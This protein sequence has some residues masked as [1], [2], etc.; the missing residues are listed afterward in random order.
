MYYTTDINSGEKLTRAEAFPG[1]AFPGGIPSEEQLADA[2]YIAVDNVATDV[3]IN[4]K[5]VE[6]SPYQDSEGSWKTYKELSTQVYP[7]I[8]SNFTHKVI[9][10]DAPYEDDGVWIT[11]ELVELSNEEQWTNIREWR[12]WLLVESDYTQASDIPNPI[13]DSNK[14]LWAT[15]RQTLRDIPTDFTTPI[16]VIFPTKPV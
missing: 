10:L 5:A 1:W 7:N 4:K 14:Q 6:V 12:D 2:G 16:D 9:T 8:P 15:Y 11:W 3:T 13:T